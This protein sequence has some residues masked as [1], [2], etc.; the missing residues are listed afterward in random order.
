MAIREGRHRTP[1]GSSLRIGSW[2]EIDAASPGFLKQGAANA[3]LVPGWSGLLVQEE[4]MIF[5]IYESQERD[6]Y[7]RLI[8]KANTLSVIWSGAGTK[9]WMR[10]TPLV[11][12]A[13]GRVIPA[14]QM[15]DSTGLALGD[16]LGWDGTRYIKA[17][18]TPE[19]QLM[20]V[21]FLSTDYVEAVLLAHGKAL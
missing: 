13:D 15:F 10:N 19:V 17:D 5:S 8:A 2:V 16:Y 9:I 12:R 20:R 18:L 3:D 14:V 21:T 4:H 6:S 1:V 7:E 11:N